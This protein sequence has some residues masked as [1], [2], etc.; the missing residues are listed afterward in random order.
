VLGTLV[1]LACLA[2][3]GGVAQG[4]D[5]AADTSLLELD[6]A[7]FTGSRSSSTTVATA[8]TGH[9]LEDPTMASA[10]VGDRDTV[11]DLTKVMGG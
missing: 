6:P 4:Q 8:D 2:L 7:D 3:G 5:E 10:S 1:A 9:G 11:T